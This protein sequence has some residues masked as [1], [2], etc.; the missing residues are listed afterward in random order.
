MIRLYFDTTALQATLDEG[1]ILNIQYFKVYESI[2]K[3]GNFSFINAYDYNPKVDYIEVP[4]ASGTIVS[5]YSDYTNWFKLSYVAGYAGLTAITAATVQLT[6]LTFSATINSVPIQAKS[7]VLKDATVTIGSTA[8]G[9]GDQG[10][11]IY[12]GDNVVAC[13]INYTTGIIQGTLA[14]TPVGALTA[15]FSYYSTL[16]EES[17]LSDAVLGE[18]MDDILLKLFTAMGDTDRLDPAFTDDEFILKWKEAVRIFKGREGVT[19]LHESEISTVIILV[20]ISC[21]YDLAYDTAKYSKLVLPEGLELHKGDR[22]KYYLDI[23]KQLELRYQQIIG[24]LGGED[25]ILSGTPSF[26]VVDET[27]KTYFNTS[28]LP[29]NR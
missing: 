17:E 22:V 25:G 20:R 3:N 12:T 23:A 8:L 21:C 5:G 26:E 24:D 27:K 13:I 1:E 7:V 15:D 10:T 11:G 29:Y 28:R 9:Q 16:N 6:G 2:S 19:H 14:T 18:K 4:L